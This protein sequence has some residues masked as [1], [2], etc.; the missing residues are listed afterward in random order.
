MIAKAGHDFDIILITGEYYDDHPLSPVG[1]IAK[2]LDAKGYRVGIIEKPLTR[3]HYTNL[4]APRLCFG[5]TSGSIDSM[6]HNYTPMKR[7]RS[8]D[9][10][11]IMHTMPDRAVIVYCNKIKE[12][13]KPSTIVIGGIEASLRRFAHYDYW[14]NAV[15]RSILLDSRADVLVYGNGEKQILEITSR[16]SKEREL[17]GIEGTCILRK[18]LDPTFELLPS[19]AEVTQDKKKFCEMQKQ[20][21]NSK[22]LAQEYTNNYVLHN[23]YPRYTTEDLDWIYS[24][25]FSRKLHPRSLLKMVSSRS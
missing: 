3:E 10:H 24:L 20:F 14:E 21:S 25:P 6:L 11:S 17:D 8:E 12:Y 22:N 19:L 9:K 15:R 13:F 23:K 1:I 7:K 16:L 4:G 2:V 5:V 18:G